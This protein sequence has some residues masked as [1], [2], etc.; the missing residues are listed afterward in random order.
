[1][2]TINPSALNSGERLSVDRS[3]SDEPNARTAATGATPRPV[4]N[5]AWSAGAFAFV[6][7]FTT[8]QKEPVTKCHFSPHDALHRIEVCSEFVRSGN[9]DNQR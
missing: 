9:P 1:V 6:R 2:A 8:F 3:S 5:P 7:H 4:F